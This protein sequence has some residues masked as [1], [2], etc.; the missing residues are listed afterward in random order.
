M[1]TIE[2]IIDRPLTPHN[3]GQDTT[4]TTSQVMSMPNIPKSSA[5]KIQYSIPVS[6][7]PSSVGGQP[8]TRPMLSDT[9]I[10]PS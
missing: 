4:P 1:R 10:V 5:P 8:P 7:I 9:G 3:P 6:S 2:S